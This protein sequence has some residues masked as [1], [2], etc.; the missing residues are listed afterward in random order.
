M[1]GCVGRGGVCWVGAH[2][3]VR[4]GNGFRQEFPSQRQDHDESERGNPEHG[5]PTEI[6]DEAD[7]E[8]RRDGAADRDAGHHDGCG[9]G[10]QALRDEVRGQRVRGRHE[11][12]ET[13][14]GNEPAHAEKDRVGG[15]RA[16]DREDGKQGGAREDGIFAAHPVREAA[17]EQRA[18]QHPQERDRSERPGTRAIQTPT[19]VIN[20]RTLDGSIDNEVISVKDDEQ[21]AQHDGDER[22]AL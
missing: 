16:G 4:G 22:R 14:S 20:E 18:N 8:E 11:P 9:H 15:E 12:A 7:A 2:C 6:R 3:R 19:G 21:P 10:A 13:E 5:L 1:R 17:G